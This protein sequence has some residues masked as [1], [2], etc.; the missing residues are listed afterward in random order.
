[1][2]RDSAKGKTGG[3]DHRARQLSSARGRI[4]LTV[5]YYWFIII[6]NSVDVSAPRSTSRKAS[7][8]V[9]FWGEPGLGS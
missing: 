7:G 8:G 6:T 9:I 3:R 5:G 1:M 4:C 2:G